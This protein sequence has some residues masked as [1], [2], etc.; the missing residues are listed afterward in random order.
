M[1]LRTAPSTVI[2]S[3]RRRWLRDPGLAVFLLVA[4]LLLSLLSPIREAEIRL[5]DTYFRL[6]RSP[7]DHSP[8][9]L[10]LID[11]RSLQAYGRWPWS[12]TLLA[13]MTDRL[14]GADASAIG[15]DILL[16][17]P[18]SPAA[19]D[20]LAAAFQHAGRVVIVD[21]LA[22]FPDGVRWVE[23]L[24][25]FARLAAIGHAQA[26]LDEDGI[27]RRLPPEELTLDGPR[28]AF[29]IQV[30]Q[31]IAPQQTVSFLRSYGLS[32][33]ASGSAISFASPRLIPIP[34][35]RDGFRT[36]SAAD[37]LGQGSLSEIQGKPVLV[38][39]GPSE[40]G[41]RVETPL[42]GNLP[43]PGVEVHAQM[44]DGILAGR[45]LH[46]LGF[47][48]STLL[49][50][51]VSLLAVA[52]FR[53][54]RGWIG[55]ACFLLLGS[56]VYALG[57]GVFVLGHM[58]PIGMLLAAVILGPLVVYGA[59]FVVVERSLTLQLRGLQSWL[60]AREPGPRRSGDLPWK[61]GLL[62][63]LQT[64]LGTLYE[65]HKTLL[66]S[67]RDGVAIF[68]A[69]GRLLL[70]NN[71]F[72][73]LCPL[74]AASLTLA[75]F[76]AQLSAREDS[77]LVKTGDAM[78]GEVRLSNDLYLLHQTPLAPT[79]IAP[80]GGTLLTLASLRARE[81][82]DQARAEA[83]AFV[84]HELRTPLTS[85]QGFAELM[86]HYPGSPA[87]AS[88][89]ETI[90]RESKRLLALI[91][92]YLDVLRLDA[93]AKVLQKSRLDVEPIVQQVF[94]LLQPLAAANEMQ[95]VQQLS[96]VP[97]AIEGDPS[98]VQGAILNLISNAIKYGKRGT[99]ILVTCRRSKSEI[100]IAVRNYG[101][102]I[103]PEQTARLFDAL[104]R[105]PDAEAAAP[106]WGLGLAFVKRMA[107]KHG[108]SVTVESGQKATTFELHF[109][110]SVVE[111]TPQTV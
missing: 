46:L 45:A 14:A 75:Q 55:F 65:L 77:P 19:D 102:P 78:E 107:Q 9:V 35:R 30:A 87:C 73:L 50:L 43:M 59:D 42:S 96:N 53:R 25:E 23:P 15:I 6:A 99:E 67:I 31:K 56:G 93:G 11:D 82:R 110:A 61:L 63:T 83:L 106:G 4:V 101:R 69:E 36:I 60:S 74:P 7:R 103:P 5:G 71:A 95:L 58:L 32:A 21:K 64:E 1:P 18:Q 51:A 54:S 13:H 88:A 79:S 62:Q 57:L 68:D 100:V 105:A 12:R 22:T 44:L 27:C 76:R 85:I 72:E 97:A 111:T 48:T 3:P 94:E 17:E 49:L 89:P 41:D 16:A 66:E 47:W 80:Q 40:L 26:V 91:N 38:G 70:W 29:A 24:P 2:S 108:G 37:V 10:V 84:T 39:F 8:V 92:S 104:Y 20:A 28:W 81:E 90:A 98:L 33:E 52:V 34:F 109:P 86:T